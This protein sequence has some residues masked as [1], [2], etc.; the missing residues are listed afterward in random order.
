MGLAPRAELD[1]RTTS[2]ARWHGRR[3][4]AVAAVVLHRRD[5]RSGGASYG[6]VRDALVDLID[7]LACGLETAELGVE[8]TR[9]RS[10]LRG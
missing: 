2:V 4:S 1:C 6:L 7:D 3:P 8:G 5:G 9:S 10:T